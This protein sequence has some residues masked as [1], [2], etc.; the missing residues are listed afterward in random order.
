MISFVIWPPVQG[1]GQVAK[2]VKICIY[3]KRILVLIALKTFYNAA[4]N[5]DWPRTFSYS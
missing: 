1:D 4:S 2:P 5:H 3:V